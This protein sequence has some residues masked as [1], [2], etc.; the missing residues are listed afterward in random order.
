MYVVDT[1]RYNDGP[2]G[3][4]GPF[5]TRQEARSYLATLPARVREWATVRPVLPVRLPAG[6]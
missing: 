5:A 3:L 1:E 4:V 2:S 6:R